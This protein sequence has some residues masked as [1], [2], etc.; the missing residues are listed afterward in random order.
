M[1][2]DDLGSRAAEL[3]RRQQVCKNEAVTLDN[4]ASNDIDQ[5]LKHRS[6][7]CKGVK[8]AVLAAWVDMLGK[9]IQKFDVVLPTSELNWTLIPVDAGGG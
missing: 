3:P 2:A 5:V 7:K 9:L 6:I 4:F 1:L 8:F